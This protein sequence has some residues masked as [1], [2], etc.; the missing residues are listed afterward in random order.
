MGDVGVRRQ[1]PSI[2]SRQTAGG[3]GLTEGKKCVT[4]YGSYPAGMVE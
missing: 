4:I 1:I 2:K 3:F